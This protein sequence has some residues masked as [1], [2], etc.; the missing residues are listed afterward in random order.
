MKNRREFIL[1]GA[2]SLLVPKFA[3]SAPV[4]AMLGAEGIHNINDEQTDITAASYIKDGL[5]ALWDGIENAGFG[6]HDDEAT[7]WTDL[8]GNGYDGVFVTSQLGTGYT[9]E[10]N[11]FVRHANN[12]NGMWTPIDIS[13]TMLSAC[14]DAT[15]SIQ[16]VT[17]SP[18]VNDDWTTQI[19]NLCQT[20][21]QSWA[22]G[23]T[24]LR[25]TA[26]TGVIGTIAGYTYQTTESFYINP[27]DAIASVSLVLDGSSIA[28]YN[29]T[30]LMWNKKPSISPDGTISGVFARLGSSAYAFRG[31]YMSYRIYNRP[32]TEAEV[33]YNYVIDNVRFGA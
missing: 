27:F 6:I 15:F 30:R 9:W 33:A 20:A 29:G 1:G 4:K 12:A 3:T 2:A 18:V 26:S 28:L 11:A 32:L 5:I 23:I 19:C 31:R 17:G 24:G 10:P 22:T 14:R 16:M 8:S 25:R 7:V 21:S 13:D